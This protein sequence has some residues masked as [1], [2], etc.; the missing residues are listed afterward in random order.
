[1]NPAM[2]VILGQQMESRG[3]P[4]LLTVAGR[5]RNLL[6]VPQIVRLIFQAVNAAAM[7]RLRRRRENNAI[8]VEEMGNAREQSWPH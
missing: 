5:R 3:Q 7:G 2:G 6:S 1:M 4:A 8:A